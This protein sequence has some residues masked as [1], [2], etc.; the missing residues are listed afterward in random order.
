[1]HLDSTACN[2]IGMQSNSTACTQGCMHSSSRESGWKRVDACLAG[3]RCAMLVSRSLV[4]C[5]LVRMSRAASRSGWPSLMVGSSTRH[6]ADAYRTWP[7]G[8]LRASWSRSLINNL[9][10]MQHASRSTSWT[11]S[12]K[13]I[14][15]GNPARPSLILSLLSNRRKV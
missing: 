10:S 4:G 6:T 8:N 14:A 9:L 13:Q 2:Q 11:M 5:S 12:S 3:R 15:N 7:L 1:M